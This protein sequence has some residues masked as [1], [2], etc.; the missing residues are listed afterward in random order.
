M[1]LFTC[2][3]TCI[4]E[5]LFSDWIKN[6]FC[7]LSDSENWFCE[8]PRLYSG[9]LC[10]FAT[11]ENNPCRN[12]ATCV[13]KSGPDFVCLCPYGRSGLLCTDGK[14][15]GLL[16]KGPRQQEVKRAELLRAIKD[17]T[18]PIKYVKSFSWFFSSQSRQDAL[19]R[20]Y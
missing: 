20:E 18:Q 19:P 10:Q 7:L 4:I 3:Y 16:S 8:C 13:P 9:K 11:C 15:I 1:I 2:V 6:S 12:G 17:N 5:Q 14:S